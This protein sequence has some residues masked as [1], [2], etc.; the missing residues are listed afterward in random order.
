MTCEVEMVDTAGIVRI[1][2]VI[3]LHTNFK[4]IN[5]TILQH[6]QDD[7]C[8]LSRNSTIGVDGYFI[9]YSIVSKSS[10]E[11]VRNLNNFLMNMLGDPPT[12]PRILIGNMS[13]L[14]EYR[15][16]I[17]PPTYLPLSL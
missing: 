2:T 16:V 9:V 11:K 5:I 13:D 3:L 7:Y 17:S 12:M 14:S 10:F 15:Y 8:R 1:S 6:L 4:Y